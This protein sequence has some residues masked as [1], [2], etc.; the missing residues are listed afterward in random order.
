MESTGLSST[1]PPFDTNCSHRAIS[2]FKL[3]EVSI[4]LSVA[5]RHFA[6]SISFVD[7]SRV[8]LRGSGNTFYFL[9]DTS[10]VSLIFY[11][12]KFFLNFIKKR[13]D[14]SFNIE[15]GDRY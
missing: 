1:G 10:N 12:I 7:L 5:F 2:T 13:G 3:R 4:S 6:L 14:N 15:W 8:S 9:K 11:N